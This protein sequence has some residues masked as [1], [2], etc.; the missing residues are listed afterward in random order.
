MIV[1]H[2]EVDDPTL[3]DL[4]QECGQL[5]V[6]VSVLPRYVDALGPSVEVDDI[7]GVTVL[8][9]NPLVLSRSSRCIKRA[10]DIV[11]SRPGADPRCASDGR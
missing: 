9:L 6:K 2:A 8:G 11:G 1:S 7:E 3:L 4:L 10:I 5:S